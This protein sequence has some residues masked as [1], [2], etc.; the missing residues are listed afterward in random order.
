[1]A[2]ELFLLTFLLAFAVEPLIPI[3]PATISSCFSDFFEGNVL[4]IIFKD[5]L[6]IIVVVGV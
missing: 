4:A 6:A 3:L 5:V 2:L 1:V